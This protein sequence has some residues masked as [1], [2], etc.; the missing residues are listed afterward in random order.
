[1][2]LKWRNAIR[3][4][5]ALRK[6]TPIAKPYLCL[7][8]FYAQRGPIEQ[9]ACPLHTQ[10]PDVL[11]RTQPSLLLKNDAEMRTGPTDH[12]RKKADGQIF[13]EVGVNVLDDLLDFRTQDPLT[14]DRAE[15]P[16]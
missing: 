16:V 5:E 11:S 3:R 6:L 2:I 7:N 1:M 4:L 14:V 13:Y 8:L 15:F 9:A 10:L 12:A